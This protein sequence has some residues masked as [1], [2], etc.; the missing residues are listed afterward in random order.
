MTSRSV[1]PNVNQAPN[2]L[3]W[4]SLVVLH[5]FIPLILLVCD[6]NFGWWQAWTF[7]ILFYAAGIG[8]RILAEKR[9][10]G[11]LVERAT[12]GKTLNAKPWDK[13]LAPLMAISLSFP[14]VIVA[15][16]DHRYAW[17]PVFPIWLNIL[18]LA[19]VALGYAFA[20]WA[21]I[22]NRFFSSTVHIQTDRGH[23]VC[24]SGPYRFVRH[25]GYAGSILS[26]AGIIMAL[27]S[28]WTIMPSLVALV[29]SVIRTMLEDK[30]LQDE[31]PGYREYTRRARYRLLPGIY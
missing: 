15:G 22:E 6:G 8:G 5:L 1:D 25:P 26:L 17:T 7:S 13:V 30:T 3:Q 21:L 11:I 27:N 12:S 18:G 24:D 20:A 2:S 29:V 31:L 4:F 9:H 28:L 23:S 16:L 19:L 14:L 10:P